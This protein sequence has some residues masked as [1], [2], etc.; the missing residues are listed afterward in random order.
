MKTVT[1]TCKEIDSF[2]CWITA[3][4]YT[5]EIDLKN[6]LLQFNLTGRK[7]V[8]EWYMMQFCEILYTSVVNAG[9]IYRDN[10]DKKTG[11]LSFRIQL[12]EILFLKCANSVECTVPDE[13]SSGIAVPRLAG[14]HL[15]GTL[16]RRRQHH[17]DD[18]LF[19]R[20]MERGRMD[21]HCTDLMN[22]TLHFVWQAFMFTAHS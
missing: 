21:G 4:E 20:R 3:G 9:M 1:V 14:R 6:Q 17:R 2:K 5:S 11:Q 16:P 18:M 8:N 15:V 19:V 13:H 7:Y 12:V 22:V 10:I